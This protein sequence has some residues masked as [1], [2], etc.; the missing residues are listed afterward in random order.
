M[1]RVT[2]HSPQIRGAERGHPGHE[3]HTHAAELRRAARPG[4]RGGAGPPA[5][6]RPQRGAATSDPERAQHQPPGQHRV[7]RQEAAGGRDQ[8]EQ[9]LV[10]G[11]RDL[12]PLRGLLLR[13]DAL[14]TTFPLVAEEVLR[15]P[16][17]AVPVCSVQLDLA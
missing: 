16:A 7:P 11:R 15:G 4:G 9:G 2:P 13:R 8:G 5:G 6:L 1:C 3:A 14:L 10:R 17:A 12:Q